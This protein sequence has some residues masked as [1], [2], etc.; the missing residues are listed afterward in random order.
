[1][2]TSLLRIL[3]SL[4]VVFDRSYA[5]SPTLDSTTIILCRKFSRLV[6]LSGSRIRPYLPKIL[7]IAHPRLMLVDVEEYV[8][9]LFISREVLPITTCT[10]PDPRE[11]WTN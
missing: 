10:G 5:L 3:R 2:D 8:V 11:D 7:S 6:P 1:M 9:S 4:C